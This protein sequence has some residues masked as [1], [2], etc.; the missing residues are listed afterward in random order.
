M[1]LFNRL[2][3]RRYT[4]R[5]IEIINGVMEIE[6]YLNY[7]LKGLNKEQIGYW[8]TRRAI[9]STILFDNKHHGCRVDVRSIPD[10]LGP[11][12][13]YKIQVNHKVDAPLWGGL[14]FRAKIKACVNKLYGDS[15]YLEDRKVKM[16]KLGDYVT[17]YLVEGKIKLP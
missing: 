16:T 14:K 6:E 13:E 9:L 4:E 11:Y 12:I 10:A 8:W 3:R 17:E 15:C 7:E 5:Y 1:F 2:Y